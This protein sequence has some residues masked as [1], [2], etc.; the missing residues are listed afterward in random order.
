MKYS[1]FFNL[2]QDATDVPVTITKKN[3]Y[4]NSCITNKIRV[5]VCKLLVWKYGALNKKQVVIKLTQ[6]NDSLFCMQKVNNL[7][8]GEWIVLNLFKDIQK[9]DT[10]LFDEL[11]EYLNTEIKQSLDVCKKKIYELEND[12]SVLEFQDALAAID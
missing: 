2:L 9:N 1:K 3:L 4:D 5:H 11:I 8:I 7:W 12:N 6:L 10:N